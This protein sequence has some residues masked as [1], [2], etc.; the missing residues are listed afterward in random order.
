[1]SKYGQYASK[2]MDFTNKYG[3][4]A[5][6]FNNQYQ[7]LS[8][9]PPPYVPA[10][11]RSSYGPQPASYGGPQASQSAPSSSSNFTIKAIIFLFF[12]IICTCLSIIVITQM[13][14]LIDTIQYQKRTTACYSDEDATKINLPN[15][16]SLIRQ[17]CANTDNGEYT[18]NWTDCGNYKFSGECKSKR[19]DGILI[20]V[21][22][23]IVVLLLLSSSTVVI[24]KL[25]R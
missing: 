24:F 16:D 10:S 21:V 15:R 11:Y 13:T 23:L 22:I 9:G 19:K 17:D 4:K 25:F 1:M 14:S 8:S 18:G 5:M 2:F 20:S 3:S 12:C 6:E 7:Q